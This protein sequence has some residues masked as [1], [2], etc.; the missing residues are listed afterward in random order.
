MRDKDVGAKTVQRRPERKWLRDIRTVCSWITLVPITV[1]GKWQ[2][3]MEPWLIQECWHLYYMSIA[4]W[5]VPVNL[6]QLV[7]TLPLYLHNP[8]NRHDKFL[9]SVLWH[10]WLGDRKGI[11]SVK[12]WTLVCWWWWFDWSFARLIA[13]VVQLLP[14]PP[15]SSFASI[16]TG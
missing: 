15:P 12:N 14:P 10:W 8:V 1:F 13:P 3:P 9:P 7:N 6:R 4:A 16:N 2:R 5:L 11:Q